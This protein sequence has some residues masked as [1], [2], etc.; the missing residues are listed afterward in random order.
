MSWTVVEIGGTPA[1]GGGGGGGD[2]A[3]AGG[4]P[5]E[6]GGLL[7][8]SPPPQAV[9]DAAAVSAIRNS[10][11]SGFIDCP[12]S[13]GVSGRGHGHR[14]T[15][16]RVDQFVQVKFGISATGVPTP[17]VISRRSLS[18][19]LAQS[20]S[21]TSTVVVPSVTKISI[22]RPVMP[23]RSVFVSGWFQIS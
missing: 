21:A 10:R 7:P 2:G 3:G 22:G 8:P 20:A 18:S 5:P 15:A 6:G 19:M 14:A 13:E 17:I 9:R 23:A 1:G 4:F 12:S 16:R 11:V